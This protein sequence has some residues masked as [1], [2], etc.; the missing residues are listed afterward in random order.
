[1]NPTEV[2]SEVD[3][4]DIYRTFHTKTKEYNFFSAPHGSFLKIDHIDTKQA[5]T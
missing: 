2:M 1:M 4:T 3:L 5:S